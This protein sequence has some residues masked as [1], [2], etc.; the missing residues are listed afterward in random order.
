MKILNLISYTNEGVCQNVGDLFSAL[1]LRNYLFK[2]SC[3]WKTVF[4]NQEEV[5]PQPFDLVILGGGGLYHPGHLKRLTEVVNWEKFDKPLA[6]VGLGLNLDKGMKLKKKDEAIIKMINQ[7]SFISSCRDLWT[8]KF[9]K[10]LGIKAYLTGCPTTFLA[11]FYRLSQRKKYDFGLNLCLY[12][13]PWYQKNALKIT[14]FIKNILL[15][16]EGEK[17][18]ICHCQEEPVLLEK[19][20]GRNLYFY[21]ISPQKIF[22]IYSQAKMIIGMRSHSQIFSLGV[23]TPSLP[24]DS[25]EK[26]IQPIK[27][28]WPKSKNLIINLDDNLKIVERKVKYLTTHYR[29]IKKKQKEL[30]KKLYRNF[31]LVTKKIK[32]KIK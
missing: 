2:A 30:K 11:D 24:I 3:Q 21:S 27:M 13:T 1:S 16:I 7:K 20:F 17:V 9:L 19:I 10:K 22:E 14:L 29:E 5:D 6:I 8:F 31:V 15:K 25:N 28:Y 26:V 12:H 23:G 18:F 32:E 4:F